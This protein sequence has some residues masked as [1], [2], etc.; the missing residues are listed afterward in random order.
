[1][2]ILNIGLTGFRDRPN[3]RNS[4]YQWYKTLLWLFCWWTL[5]VWD[6]L[7]TDRDR[8]SHSSWPSPWLVNISIISGKCNNC[9][10][11]GLTSWDETAEINL[12]LVFS[13]CQVFTNKHD[14]RGRPTLIYMNLSWLFPDLSVTI[15]RRLSISNTTTT[16]I[17]LCSSQLFRFK[18]AEP[19]F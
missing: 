17:S 19:T 11:P 3:A 13:V 5:E 15:I 1:M 10:A 14:Q 18:K 9:F 2:S 4:S 7:Q 16:T 8:L 6:V 12:F